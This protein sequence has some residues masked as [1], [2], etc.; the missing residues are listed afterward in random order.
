MDGCFSFSML[1]QFVHL[2]SPLL[3]MQ[4]QHTSNTAFFTPL[5]LSLSLFLFKIAIARRYRGRS[6]RV[7]L[8]QQRESG[9]IDPSQEGKNTFAPLAVHA[10]VHGEHS[11]TQQLRR[12][13]TQ[14]GGGGGS[15][16]GQATLESPDLQRERMGDDQEEVGERKK[17]LLNT[18]KHHDDHHLLM[19]TTHN[20][21]QFD[22]VET[23]AH[24]LVYQHGT[25]VQANAATMVREMNNARKE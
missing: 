2:L 15:G 21:R 24:A 11:W 9:R 5:S 23:T 19:P 3:S 10:F 1:N 7:K 6:E 13:R 14:V 16:S 18:R 17:N 12:L 4:D 8:Q 20:P 25:W 22:A